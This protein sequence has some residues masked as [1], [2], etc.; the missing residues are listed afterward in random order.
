[1]S[2]SQPTTSV[3]WCVDA[4]L[5]PEFL[6]CCCIY[7]C[8]LS[9]WAIVVSNWLAHS[10]SSK[11]TSQFWKDWLTQHA[12]LKEQL[13][14]LSAN[15]SHCPEN[16]QKSPR[17]LGHMEEHWERFGNYEESEKRAKP[18]TGYII[19]CLVLTQSVYSFLLTLITEV[20]CIT[21]YMRYEACLFW[22]RMW[23]HCLL[24]VRKLLQ[25]LAQTLCKR[26]QSCS[27]SFPTPDC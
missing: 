15:T 12:A 17:E 16:P 5:C 27:L 4:Y 24:S 6:S 21:V 1:M 25:S 8:V 2:S 23:T 20:F 3:S 13:S 10:M 14:C 9:P 18:P 11:S 19:H 7:M 26:N 22:R